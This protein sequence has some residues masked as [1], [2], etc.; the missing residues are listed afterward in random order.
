MATST[1]TF[2]PVDA[3]SPVDDE[4]NP[5]SRPPIC[6]SDT[7]RVVPW[8]DPIADPHGVHPC[9]R[10]VELYWLGIL[11]PSTTWLLR[12][13]SYGSMSTRMDSISIS[14]KRPD[15]WASVTAWERTLRSGALFIASPPS[16]WPGPTEPVAWL[17]V[18]ASRR[19]PCVTSTDCPN[20]S[21]R[22]TGPG[23]PNNVSPNPNRC[24]AAPD[25]WRLASPPRDTTGKRSN[26]AWVSGSSTRRWR[27]KPPKTR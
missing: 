20:L 24:A 12:R 23:W 19:Y 27:F 22:A 1:V 17:S 4:S 14:P 25:A 10:Y 11:G 26:G 21:N 3:E 2:S 8:K 9:S 6:T 18:P 16:S 7:L 13:M 15:P 5:P